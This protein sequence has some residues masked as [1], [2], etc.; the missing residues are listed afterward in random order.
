MLG[1]SV[2][3]GLPAADSEGDTGEAACLLCLVRVGVGFC[4]EGVGGACVCLLRFSVPCWLALEEG[5]LPSEATAIPPLD[6][7][8]A[9]ATADK[10]A[11][12]LP[13]AL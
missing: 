11:S 9:A 12:F 4:L 2:G 10:S 7:L 6:M 1:V 3:E 5:V 8:P 13:R